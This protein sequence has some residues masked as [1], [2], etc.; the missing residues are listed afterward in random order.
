MDGLLYPRVRKG[1]GA[2]EFYAKVYILWILI[3]LRINASLSRKV[4]LLDVEGARVLFQVE[5]LAAVDTD[6]PVEHEYAEP[7]FKR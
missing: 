1:H 2:A 4:L 6:F 7:D 3:V 5:E